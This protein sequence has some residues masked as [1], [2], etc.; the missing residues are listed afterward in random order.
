M[1]VRLMLWGSLV[2][3]LMVR[4]REWDGRRWDGGEQG[5]E[6]LA[7]VSSFLQEE[8]GREVVCYPDRFEPLRM[9]M[10]A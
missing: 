1:R 6:P 10:S 4:H 2:V 9:L 7:S 3:V 5:Q 8:A